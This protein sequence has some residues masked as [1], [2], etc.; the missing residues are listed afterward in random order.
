MIQLMCRTKLITRTTE[1][2]N[3]LTLSG[4]HKKTSLN[5]LKQRREDAKETIAGRTISLL[6]MMRNMTREK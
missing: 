6:M 4:R 2:M 1:M 3:M 5:V